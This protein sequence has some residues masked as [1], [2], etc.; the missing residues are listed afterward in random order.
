M[1]DDEYRKLT[2][3]SLVFVILLMSKVRTITIQ[4]LYFH[5][6]ILIHTKIEAS[7]KSL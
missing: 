7:V 3:V 2:P 4:I 1:A 5:N 6:F